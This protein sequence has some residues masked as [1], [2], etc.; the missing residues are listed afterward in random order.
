MA[1]TLP[2]ILKRLLKLPTAPFHEYHVRAEIEAM[3][4]ECPHVKLR[5]DKFGNLLA[6]YKNGKIK[7]KP[8]WV[9]A[10]HMDHPAFVKS[11][12]GWEFLGGSATPEMEVA[13]KSG[14]RKAKGGIGV[15][16]FPVKV[17][18]TRIEAAACDDLI[19]CAVIVMTFLELARL[20]IH[21]TVHAAFTRAEEVGWLGAWHLA[22]NWPF[23]KEAV[24]VSIETSRPVNGAVMGQGPMVR[25]GDR[26]SV[27]DSEAVAVLTTTAK[28]QAIRVQRCLLDA[29]ACE[30][31]AVQAA[32]VRSVGISIPLGNYHNIGVQRQIAPEFVMMDDVKALIQLLKALVATKHDG[33]GERTIRERVEMRM[34]EHAEHF[35]A[36]TK[37]FK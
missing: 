37:L 13:V 33:I 34:A 24:F 10:A 26:V 28:E 18:N 5:K 35:K 1:H 20:G 15:W 19:G 31:T 7:S 14:L 6:T 22:Q 17:T 9:F 3:L 8:T 27:F 29:G 2:S 21:T 11:E 4:K 16:N 12:D 30:A 23:G 36:G 32:G 25:V